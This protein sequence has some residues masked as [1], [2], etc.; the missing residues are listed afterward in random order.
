VTTTLPNSSTQLKS[1][2]PKT[3]SLEFF[4]KT[5]NQWKSYTTDSILNAAVSL[6]TTTNFGRIQ[7]QS[8]TDWSSPSTYEMRTVYKSTDSTHINSELI[9]MWTLNLQSKCGGYTLTKNAQIADITIRDDG[10]VGTGTPS[11]SYS[12]NAVALSTCPLETKLYSWTGGAWEVYSVVAPSV[13]QTTFN[14]GSFATAN[15]GQYRF[16]VTDASSQGSTTTVKH[17]KLEI[18]NP[19]SNTPTTTGTISFEFN[20][21][22]VYKCTLDQLGH[23]T[24][25]GAKTVEIQATLNLVS[26]SFSSSASQL[27]HTVASCPSNRVLQYL[28]D[29]TATWET[30]TGNYAAYSNFISSATATDDRF[31]TTDYGKYDGKTLQFRYQYTNPVST[32]TVNSVVY[33]NFSVTFSYYCRADTVTLNSISDLTFT[34]GSADA[35]VAFTK[36]QSPASTSACA[37]TLVIEAFDSVTQSFVAVTSFP[38]YRSSTDAQLVVQS[39]ASMLTS[40]SP[41]KDI[42]VRVTY[43]STYSVQTTKQA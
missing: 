7:I 37:R 14:T 36:S 13:F 34:L 31:G 16:E 26:V 22:T 29:N 2:C 39:A 41:K 11:F 12:G 4:D 1:N 18:K 28:N 23:S 42:S 43:T 21:S 35:T 38:F 27:T 25:T 9:D 40:Y 17:L 6:D 32:V 3:V 24:S 33:D 30:V 20:L 19:R 5:S 10:T 8:A 15:V